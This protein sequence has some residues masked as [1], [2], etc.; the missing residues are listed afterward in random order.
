MALNLVLADRRRCSSGD[1]PVR[2]FHTPKTKINLTTSKSFFDLVNFSEFPT[3]ATEPPLLFDYTD[4]DL[5]KAVLDNSF[6]LPAIFNHSQSN[7]F[8]VS[9]T[10]KAA[11]KYFDPDKRQASILMTNSSRQKYPRDAKK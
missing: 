9:N 8:A 6:N 1:E 2:Q 4:D 3:G 5:K 10:T 11:K 7:E